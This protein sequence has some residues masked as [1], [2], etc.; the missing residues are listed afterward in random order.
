MSKIPFDRGFHA[1]TWDFWEAGHGKGAPDGAGAVIKRTADSLVSRGMDIPNAESLFEKLVAKSLNVQLFYVSSDAISTY[2]S[3]LPNNL[4]V[5]KGTLKVRQAFTETIGEI[6]VR[7]LSCYCSDVLSEICSCL[8]P[9]VHNTDPAKDTKLH[10]DVLPT[11]EK[12]TATSK[13][14]L[15]DIPES[16]VLPERLFNKWCIVDYDKKPF[17][18]KILQADGDGIEVTTMKPIGDNKFVWPA[19]KDILW[20]EYSKIL[21]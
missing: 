6:T 5:I 9:R 10:D 14:S 1:I 12:S 8:N 4:D 19:V 3:V 2:D 16:D 13:D 11:S 18:G 17:L 7:N 20:Y 15:L 21:T